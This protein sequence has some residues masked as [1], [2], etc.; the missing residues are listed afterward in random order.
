LHVQESRDLLDVFETGMAKKVRAQPLLV[1]MTTADYDR[2]SV[3]NEVYA[4]AVAVRDNGGDPSKPGYDPYFLPVVYEVPQ[5]DDWRDE[6]VWHKANPN[7]GV[8]VS[9]ESLRGLCAKAVESP[10]FEGAFRRLHLNQRTG[11]E[12]KVI[13]MDQWDACGADFAI[14][15]LRSKPCFGGLDLASVE[16]IA[17]FALLFPE[18]NDKCK[19]L[20]W[21]W[22]PEERIARRAR[23]KFPYDVWARAGWLTATKDG[24]GQIDYGAIRQKI[25]EL[26]SFFDIRESGYDAWNATQLVQDL[27]AA[28]MKM[29]KV[30]AHYSHL[31][32]PTKELLR[33]IRKRTL[34]HRRDPV[35][36][37]AATN[38]AVKF[39]GTLPDGADIAEHLEKVAVMLS[40]KHSA[41]K[42]D[43]LTATVLAMSRLIAHPEVA[44]VSVY[45][46]R[47]LIQI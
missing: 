1:M 37:W 24:G 3:C 15:E 41:E 42:I 31:S 28:G 26:K 47:G 21:S 22:C 34:H 35:L 5:A 20:V 2:P 11:Q 46:S 23:Q 19:V 10:A 29:F 8:T 43:P 12:V 33:R 32:A 30:P 38:A 6:R 44:K 13:R 18:S 7:L 17:S 14:E 39:D 4:Q 25:L 9:L 27:E 36:R 16:D 40:K 45:E